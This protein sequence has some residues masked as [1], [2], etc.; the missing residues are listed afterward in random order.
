MHRREYLLV[1]QRARILCEWDGLSRLED[2]MHAIIRPSR[3][4]IEGAGSVPNELWE[5]LLDD[6]KALHMPGLVPNGK[7]MM[8]ATGPSG[9]VDA[10]IYR[11]GQ[12][13]VDVVRVLGKYGI[14]AHTEV[15]LRGNGGGGSS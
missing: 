2:E 6:L 14:E 9:R 1:R 4:D 8:V 10:F 13:D 12:T 7:R 3:I 5:P 15:E 11:T